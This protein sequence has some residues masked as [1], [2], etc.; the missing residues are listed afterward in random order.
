MFGFIFPIHIKKRKIIPVNKTGKGWSLPWK[1]EHLDKGLLTECEIRVNKVIPWMEVGNG[2]EG[3]GR[4][5]AFGSQF[6]PASKGKGNTFV[7]V[8]LCR[9]FWSTFIVAFPLYLKFYLNLG[10]SF[11]Y[12][13]RYG[14]IDSNHHYW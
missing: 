11:K 13:K 7:C 9:W 8:C 10:N 5:M 1:V 14:F 6:S 2:G 4:V 12:V 3:E